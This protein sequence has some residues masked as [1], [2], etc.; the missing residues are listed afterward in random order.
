MS[1]KKRSLA[2]T[3][4]SH[5]DAS[6]GSAP[7]VGHAAGHHEYNREVLLFDHR[8]E[9]ILDCIPRRRVGFAVPDDLEVEGP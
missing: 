3:D 6:P 4:Y 9:P 1:E 2:W 8:D 7:A 5:E